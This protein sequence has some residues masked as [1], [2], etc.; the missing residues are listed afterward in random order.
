[1]Q[2]TING[3]SKSIS[4]SKMEVSINWLA[5]RLMG[6]RL[7]KNIGID[8]TFVPNLRR[9]QY[10]YGLCEPADAGRYHREFD[11]SLDSTMSQK[12]I[13][14]ALCHE[15]V[16]VKQYARGELKE[17]ITQ[18]RVETYWQGKLQDPDALDY[19]D[20]PWEIEAHGRERGLFLYLA[21]H[22]DNLG[23]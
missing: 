9:K 13:L 20:R 8:L 5:E 6:P 7:A 21:D 17:R 23:I 10:V 16:H 22:F 15:M 3:V 18:S 2:L 1:M 19:W 14:E 12:S 4:N 11:I